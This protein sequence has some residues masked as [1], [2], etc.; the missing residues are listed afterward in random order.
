M[1]EPQPWLSVVIPTC[2][3]ERYLATALES[4]V[5]DEGQGVELV[6][7]DD[8]STDRTLEI[9]DTYHTRAAIRIVQRERVA[10]WVVSTNVGL[11]AATGRHACFQHQDDLWLP[12]RLS[13]IRLELDHRPWGGP[14]TAFAQKIPRSNRPRA[15]AA[16]SRVTR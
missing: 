9:V 13:A 3:G 2:N 15:Q 11:R 1:S 14:R 10:N 6:I 16:G 8:G 4:V 12:G 7:V 5:A